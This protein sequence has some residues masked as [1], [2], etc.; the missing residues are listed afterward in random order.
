[1]ARKKGFTAKQSKRTSQQMA[2]AV[3]GSHMPR[4]GK[5]ARHMNADD[6]S[7]S[8]TRQSN[9]ASR[10]QVGAI[11][12]DSAGDYAAHVGSS[13]RYVQER[14]HRARARRILGVAAVVVV[15]ALI[16]A[17]AGVSTYMSTVGSKLAL[18]DSD[19][20]SALVAETAGQP[21]YV[22]IDTELG[23]VADSLDNGGPD[24]LVL[25]RVDE[26][27]KSVSLVALPSTLGVSLDDGKTHALSDAAS[28][29]DAALIKAVDKA[30][31][32][33]VSHIIKLTATD[34]T[35]LVDALGGVTVDVS[36]EID[37]PTAGSVYLAPGTQA[38]DGES[39]LTF[40][41]ATNLSEGVK[42]QMRNQDAFA[43]AVIAQ[44]CSTSSMTFTQRID[45]V[46]SYLQT[47]MSSNDL[48]DAGNAL[49]NISVDSI[50]CAITPGSVTTGNGVTSTAAYYTA[51]SDFSSVFS[52]IEA[53]QKP[54]DSDNSKGSESVDPSQVTVTVQNG[55]GITGA[56]SAVGSYLSGLGYQVGSTGNADQQVYTSTLVVY[57]SGQDA[58]AQAVVDGLGFGRTVQNTGYYSFST[59]LLVVIGSDY[60]PLS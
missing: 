36:E 9:R 45:E 21:Y 50:I 49:A 10:G 12:P 56:A 23:Q 16:A 44:M 34:L 52:S 32:V 51:S 38:L 14:L 30:T 1:M 35:K 60:K 8:S 7:F 3:L 29:G 42:T 22:L 28:S 17:F 53:G 6:V 58:A 37:D 26:S 18:R 5:R 25:A 13:N 54:T 4:S 55:S 33:S 39:A 31:G 2:S 47:D 48:I 43:A 46:G 11:L 19:A 20:T 27:G 40:L 57:A 24:A 59:N 41:R 15:I